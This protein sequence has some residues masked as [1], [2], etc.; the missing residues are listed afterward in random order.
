VTY[1]TRYNRCFWVTVDGL[2]Q[3][4][5]RA[6]LDATRSRT[7]GTIEVHTKN[8]NVL[9]LNA[10]GVKKIEIDG[11][12]IASSGAN[13]LRLTKRGG[14]WKEGGDDSGL[15]KHHGLQG[16]IDDAFMDAFLCVRPTGHT[17]NDLAGRYAQE[18]LDLFTNDFAKYFRGQIR[19]KDDTEVTPADIE[20]SHLIVFGDPQ[21]NQIL[22][23]MAGKLPVSWDARQLSLGR[24]M[25][26]AAYHTLVM[27]YPNPLEPRRYVVLN[28]GH[29]FHANELDATNATL[30]PR[31]GDYAVLHLRQPIA[32]PVESEVVTAGY[33][34][35]EWKLPEE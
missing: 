13:D 11:Q 17:T 26:D 3:H 9:V 10:S 15:R 35:E 21:S 20:Q 34:D 5:K 33:F 1:T 8:I 16:T 27:V 30:F 6:E 22:N 19:I 12:S 32:T 25:F 7:V 29:S 2:E 4:Y 31:F 23:R 18:T 24:Q 14:V 28:S